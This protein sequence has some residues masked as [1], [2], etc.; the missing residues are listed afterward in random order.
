MVNL[1]ITF[2][3]KEESSKYRQ[4]TKARTHFESSFKIDLLIEVST[5]ICLIY[6]MLQIYSFVVI[7]INKTLRT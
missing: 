2:I 5:E 6:K 4:A 3:T 1:R 7:L